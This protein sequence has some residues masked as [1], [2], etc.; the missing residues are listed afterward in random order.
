MKMKR[1]KGKKLIGIL[2]IMGLSGAAMAQVEGEAFQGTNAAAINFFL[3]KTGIGTNAP[4]KQLHVVGDSKMEGGLTVDGAF[5]VPAQGD[6]GMGP[7]TNGVNEQGVV[8]SNLALRG[9]W[10]SYDGSSQGIYVSTNGNVGVGTSTP[11]AALQVNGGAQMDT[12]TVGG[13]L[14]V[15]NLVMV[16]TTNNAVSVNNGVGTIYTKTNWANASAY[17]TNNQPGVTFP[18][19]TIPALAGVTNLTLAGCLARTGVLCR[20]TLRSILLLESHR[21]RL[22]M[23]SI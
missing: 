4:A 5:Q 11:G 15:T 9:V 22:R 8:S 18:S 14:V 16:E 3:G 12:L 23:R 10:I 13:N 20:A 7:Y 1:H 6:I 21:E 2:L 17:L 19:A